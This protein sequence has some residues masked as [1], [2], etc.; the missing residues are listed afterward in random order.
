MGPTGPTG[1][2]G[3]SGKCPTSCSANVW[4][5]MDYTK[6]FLIGSDKQTFK[7]TTL[8]TDLVKFENANASFHFL[9]FKKVDSKKTYNINLLLNLTNQTYTIGKPNINFEFMIIG[10]S[11]LPNSNPTKYS[12]FNMSIGSPNTANSKSVNLTK[13]NPYVIGSN[14]YIGILLKTPV[15]IPELTSARFTKTYA[16]Y[17]EN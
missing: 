14:G 1:S 15:N 12:F 11:T 7:P 9:F 5:S 10:H 2:T 3:P 17:Q 8:P 13:I 4:K 16:N 6:R